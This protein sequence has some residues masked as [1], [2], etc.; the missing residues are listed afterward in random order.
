MPVRI[1]TDSATDILPGLH[2]SLTVLPLTVTF[3]AET[4]DGGT[5]LS[6]GRFY[7]LLIESG[8]LQR[9][10]TPYDARTKLPRRHFST[11]YVPFHGKQT[12]TAEIFA[13]N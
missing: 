12:P 4:Y 5:T 9:G 8:T 6:H 3:G 1:I 7:E 2:P 10:Q 13:Q 11:D